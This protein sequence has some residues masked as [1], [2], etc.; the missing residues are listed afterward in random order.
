MIDEFRET[1]KPIL[2]V[3]SEPDGIFMRALGR[4]KH[5]SL[6]SNITNDRSAVF[7]TTYIS[8]IDPYADL[9]SININYLRGYEPVILDPEQPIAPKHTQ[10][11][12]STVSGSKDIIPLLHS[13]GEVI[14]KV[15][16]YAF[17]AVWVPIGLTLFLL[18][19]GVQNF[20]S[21]RRIQLHQQ[22]KAGIPVS[23]YR[24]PLA[25]QRFG[26][27]L[28]EEVNQKQGEEYLLSEGEEKDEEEREVK[29][30][31]NSG[32]DSDTKDVSAERTITA[33]SINYPL[34]QSS[35]SHSQSHS[36]SSFPT[37]ALHPAQFAMIT[38]LNAL[39]WRKYPVH[40]HK[41]RHSHAAIIKRMERQSFEEGSV[42]VGHW[43]AEF[44]I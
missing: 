2:T 19:A 17:L 36:Q 35:Q 25:M 14:K 21:Q 37:L 32:A 23:L 1:G 43:V 31:E 39:G 34:H 33:G 12:T 3:L 28:Y 22:G 9:S 6:Y 27:E 13:S 26:E 42:V 38:S 29:G 30:N 7:Y 24:V 15:P 11:N 8:P 16:F 4:F 18:N 20:Q 41:A 10:T 40:I 5:R 44:E